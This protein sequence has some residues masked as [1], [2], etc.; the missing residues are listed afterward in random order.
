MKALEDNQKTTLMIRNIPNKYTK[1]LLM[2]EIKEKFES[3]FDFFYLPI[4]F[5]NKCNLGYAFINLKSKRKVKAFYQTFHDK[6]WRRYN[7]SKIC[8][9]TFADIQG[10][11]ACHCH[12]ENSSLMKKAD[13]KMK[14]FLGNQKRKK[15]K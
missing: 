15:K 7:S 13:N 12:F 6:K 11:E 1:K 10:K 2:E 3:Q 5:K 14:P 8:Q 4:D 9:I